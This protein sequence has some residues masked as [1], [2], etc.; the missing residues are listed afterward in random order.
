MND[1][2]NCFWTYI[3]EDQEGRFYIGHTDNL[4]RRVAEHNTPEKIGTKYT[5]KNGPWRL[6]WQEEHE[7]RSEAM[8]RERF[9]KSR[10]SSAW[11]RKY[12]LNR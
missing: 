4:D 10:K 6:V 8:R 7:T 1:A 11:I 12:L 3:L 2:P 5:H 9:I